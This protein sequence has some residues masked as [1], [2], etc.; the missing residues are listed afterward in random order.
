VN[1]KTCGYFIHRRPF[2]TKAVLL[3][4][5]T[6]EE[7]ASKYLVYPSKKHPPLIPF[8]YY[9]LEFKASSQFHSVQRMSLVN[10][11]P[12]WHTSPQRLAIAYF[13]CD[14]VYQ[15]SKERNKDALAFEILR[16]TQTKLQE[17]NNDFFLPIEFIC[18]WMEALG[19]LPEPILGATGFN[20]EE[21]VFVVDNNAPN[22]AASNWNQWLLHKNSNDKAGMKQS[23]SL[24]VRYL[25]THVP[26]FNVTP[27]LTILQQIFV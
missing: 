19:L 24:M 8:M 6:K 15:S 17:G 27:T 16:R 22:P 21:G 14:V 5:F 12:H 11:Q 18:D 9:E 20:V 2:S 10:T 7:G 26:N 1:D 4:L 3:T 25:E 13:I 23:F